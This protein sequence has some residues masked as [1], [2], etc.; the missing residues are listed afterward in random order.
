VL[1]SGTSF[2]DKIFSA[3]LDPR[4]GLVVVG[5]CSAAMMRRLSP[6]ALELVAAISRPTSIADVIATSPIPN[7]D[8]VRLLAGLLRR[9]VLC[10]PQA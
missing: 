9:A 6:A 1:R 5:A 2:L 7:R 10:R 3:R 4:D 8:C